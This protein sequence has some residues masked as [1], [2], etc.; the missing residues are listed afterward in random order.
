M[1][2]YIVVA[3]KFRPMTFDAVVGQAGTYEP[4]AD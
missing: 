3:R 2:D 1:E 4:D